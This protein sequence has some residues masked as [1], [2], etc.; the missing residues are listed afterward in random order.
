MPKAASSKGESV[1][2]IVAGV[3]EQRRAVGGEAGGGFE[4]DEAQGQDQ[5]DDQD[6]LH[7]AVIAREL[8]HVRMLMSGSHLTSIVQLLLLLYCRFH[9]FQFFAGVGPFALRGEL[10]VAVQVHADVFDA[11]VGGRWGCRS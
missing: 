1:G 2:E 8:V 6:T 7:P 3:G 4:D 5:G 11:R 10:A 9:G